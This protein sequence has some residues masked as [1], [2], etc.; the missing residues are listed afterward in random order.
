M[1]NDWSKI[2]SFKMI[3]SF[4]HFELPFP[5]FLPSPL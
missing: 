5:L 1:R 3:V 2:V 4:L